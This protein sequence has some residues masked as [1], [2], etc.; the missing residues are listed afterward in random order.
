MSVNNDTN[1]DDKLS[2]TMN[3][4]RKFPTHDVLGTDC[5]ICFQEFMEGEEIGFSYNLECNHFFHKVCIVDWLARDDRC[6]SCRRNY[7]E[8]KEEDE[9]GKVE[10]NVNITF[11]SEGDEEEGRPS[12]DDDDEEENQQL[13]NIDLEAED[14]M[15]LD[16]G[17]RQ[18]VNVDY[19]SGTTLSDDQDIGQTHI[20]FPVSVPDS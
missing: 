11:D 12:H 20:S 10:R 9:E 4:Q 2:P 8:T 13:S 14:N 16:N 5:S 19:P 3:R 7:L 6:P 17:E 15:N 1:V 18:R